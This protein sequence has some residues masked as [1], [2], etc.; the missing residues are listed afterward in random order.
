MKNLIH[1]GDPYVAL[2][3]AVPALTPAGS[4]VLIGDEG[5]KGLTLTTR[6]TTALIAEGKAAPGLADGQASV[7][8]LGVGLVVNLE[9]EST[10]SVV[11]GEAVYVDADG[12]YTDDP[13]DTF[14]G[15]ALATIL[16]EA[17]GPVALAASALATAAS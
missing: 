8:L 4:V 17:T 3:L 14:V 15:W 1:R 6:A 7:M 16:D 12:V 13:T 5:L 9:I 10:T 11:L 2:P